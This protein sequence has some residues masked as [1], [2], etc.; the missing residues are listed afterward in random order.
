MHGNVPVLSKQQFG[1]FL[2]A[3]L[4]QV[5]LYSLDGA[6]ENGSDFQLQ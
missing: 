6:Q 4:I 3:C 2:Y 5:G 1:Y